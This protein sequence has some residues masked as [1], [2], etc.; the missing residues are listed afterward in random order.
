[1]FVAL[2]IQHARRMRRFVICGL[3]GCTYTA[4][5]SKRKKE[6]K[7]IGHK[8]CVLTVYTILSEVF[9]ILR[10]TEQNM[11]KNAY[12]PSCKIQLLLSYCNWSRIFPT[13]FRKNT[14]ISN[15]IKIRP[16]GAESFHADGRTDMTE[17]IVAFRNFANEPKTWSKRPNTHLYLL[18]ELPVIL[19][20]YVISL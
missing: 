15:F 1:V 18:C 2:G 13:A 6:K 16:V 8:M 3:P 12:W 4:L 11:I 14:Y 10:R 7:V 9:F 17:L 5:F 19:C 20:L